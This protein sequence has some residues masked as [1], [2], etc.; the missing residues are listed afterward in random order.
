[1]LI[2]ESLGIAPDRALTPED[3][4]GLPLPEKAWDED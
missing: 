1:M 4:A 3:L 2:L